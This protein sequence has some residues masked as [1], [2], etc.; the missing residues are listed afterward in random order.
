MKIESN[1]AHLDKVELQALAAVGAM[2]L[3]NNELSWLI[4][5]NRVLVEGNKFI[6]DTKGLTEAQRR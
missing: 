5:H 6:S 1:T 4:L 2:A 3:G